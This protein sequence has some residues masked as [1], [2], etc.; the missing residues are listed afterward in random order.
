MGRE[1]QV[2]REPVG[3]CIVVDESG[4]VWTRGSRG[5]DCARRRDYEASWPLVAER[6]VRAVYRPEPEFDP[7]GD[8][9]V[10]VTRSKWGDGSPLTVVGVEGLV[11]PAVIGE[12]SVAI[13]PDGT[14]SLGLEILTSW[15]PRFVDLPEVKP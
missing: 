15:A 5:W 13:V 7:R 9:A 3:D 11:I 14:Y 10:V 1:G 6:G 2:V 12:V 4:D 8:E